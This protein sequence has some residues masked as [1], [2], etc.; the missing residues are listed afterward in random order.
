M[1]KMIKKYEVK[2]IIP[3]TIVKTFDVFATDNE[4]ALK[5]CLDGCSGEKLSTIT[6]EHDDVEYKVTK[7]ETTNLSV[8]NS[9]I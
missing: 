2:M 6:T 7:I 3:A 5:L 4:M 1:S 8:I 9:T